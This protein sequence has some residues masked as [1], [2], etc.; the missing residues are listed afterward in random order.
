MS[1]KPRQAAE[2]L[3]DPNFT[4]LPASL[5][6]A[7]QKFEAGDNTV[8]LKWMFFCTANHIQPPEW[9]ALAFCI[10]ACSPE[11]FETWDD[12]FGPPMPKGTKRARREE[13]KNQIPLALK[14]HE[15]KAK[16]VKGDRA[17]F[18]QAAKELG[19]ARDW[20]TVRDSFYRQPEYLRDSFKHR[21]KSS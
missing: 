5:E 13:I 14:V 1:R 8:I 2:P 6:R 4:W 9:L 11:E 16:G 3:W 17:L 18:E 19:L 12:A 10:R 7:R 15:L 20:K 21:L